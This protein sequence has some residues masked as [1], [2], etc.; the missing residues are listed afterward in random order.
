MLRKHSGVRSTGGSH[1]F[2]DVS[3]F[4]KDTVRNG[5]GKSF[6]VDLFDQIPCSFQEAPEHFLFVSFYLELG[7]T[8]NEQIVAVFLVIICVDG[9]V[10]V[11]DRHSERV[12]SV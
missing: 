6:S 8:V 1:S 12:V 9:T 10:F 2:D 3:V 4:V 5:R 11:Q 7:N